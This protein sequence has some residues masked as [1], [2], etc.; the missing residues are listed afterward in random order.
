MTRRH[1]EA[2]ASTIKDSRAVVDQRAVDFVARRLAGCFRAFN[3][4]FDRDRFLRAAGV[5]D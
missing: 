5:E 1:F 3:P 2:I 4:N